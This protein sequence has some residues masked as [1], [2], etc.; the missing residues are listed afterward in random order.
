MIQIHKSK[1][2]GFEEN[3]LIKPPRLEKAEP[4]KTSLDLL[5][6]DQ[7]SL[8]TTFAYLGKYVCWSDLK[9]VSYINLETQEVGETETDN[10]WGEFTVETCQPNSLIEAGFINESDPKALARLGNF[11][12]V[13]IKQSDRAL[14]Y[15]FNSS[16]PVLV[17]ETLDISLYANPERFVEI[18]FTPVNYYTV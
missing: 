15:N 3:E 7:V 4:G 11:L 14:I 10:I 2:V 8:K 12:Q 18:G 9:K 5:H 1:I 13:S 6:F 17:N 16:K